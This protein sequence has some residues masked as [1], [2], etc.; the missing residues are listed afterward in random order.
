MAPSFTDSEIQQLISE[1]KVLTSGD[2]ANLRVLPRQKKQHKEQLIEIPRSA[3]PNSFFKIILRQNTLNH[4]DFSAILAIGF[5]TTNL[6]FKLRR[7]NGKSHRHHNKIE[8]DLFYD[9]HIHTATERYRAN[10]YPK[11]ESFAERTDR[12]SDLHGAIKAMIEDCNVI[13]PQGS[14]QTMF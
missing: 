14:Q 4:L 9:F 3:D 1:P 2:H 11:E 5:R 8:G 7:Y 12:F 10:G 6:D 13:L